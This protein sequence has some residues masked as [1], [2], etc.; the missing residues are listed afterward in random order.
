MWPCNGSGPLQGHAM[1]QAVT[2]RSVTA[3]ARPVR[4]GFAMDSHTHAGFLQSTLVFIKVIKH[5]CH[6]CYLNLAVEG[7]FTHS[8][9]CP[10]HS[11]VMLCR[12]GFRLSF[13]HL[14]YTVQPCLI[15]TCHAMPRPCHALTMPFFSRPRHSTAIK[16]RPVGYLPAFGF[17]RLPRRSSTKIVI[18]SIPILLTTIH[19]YDCKEW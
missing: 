10:C 15:H 4:V 19:T 13:P 7:P 11:P 8:M 2:R 16:R 12:Y 17:F 3:E 9:P 1:V 14:I 18:R 6:Q 5:L